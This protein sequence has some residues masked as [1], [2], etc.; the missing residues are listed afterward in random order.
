MKTGI[1]QMSVFVLFTL[2]GIMAIAQN[3]GQQAASVDPDEIILNGELV[4]VID[5]SLSLTFDAAS[6][7]KISQ[8]S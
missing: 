8:A 1:K 5:L 2:S 3:D 6:I 7:S 4:E